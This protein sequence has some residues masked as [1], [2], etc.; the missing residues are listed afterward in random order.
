VLLEG[1][2]VVVALAADV[3]LLLSGAAFGLQRQGRRPEPMS[4]TNGIG[5]S[6]GRR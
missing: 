4:D 6:H 1:L 2:S 5:G 3:I